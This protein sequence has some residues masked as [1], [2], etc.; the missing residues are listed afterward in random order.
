MSKHLATAARKNSLLTGRH[1]KQT[2]SLDGRPSALT[3]WVERERRREGER[4][5]THTEKHNNNR[6]M[7]TAFFIQ[8]MLFKKVV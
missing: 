3:V 5:E 4:G 2:R 7:H 6:N 8:V 1:L